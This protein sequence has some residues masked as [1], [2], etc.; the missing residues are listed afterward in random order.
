LPTDCDQPTNTAWASFSYLTLSN[1]LAYAFKLL[2]KLWLD[3]SLRAGQSAP[4]GAEL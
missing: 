2:T 1:R 3:K 4:P